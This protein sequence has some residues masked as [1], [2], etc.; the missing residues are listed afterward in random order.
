[1]A[2][3]YQLKDNYDLA[4]KFYRESLDIYKKFLKSDHPSIAQTLNNM[5]VV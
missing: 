2:G 1:M 4:L 5:A 3:A